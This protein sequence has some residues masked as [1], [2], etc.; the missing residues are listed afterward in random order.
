[1]NKEVEEFLNALGRRDLDL[2]LSSDEIQGLKRAMEKIAS[3]ARLAHAI[4]ERPQ[5]TEMYECLGKEL[6]RIGDSLAF[7]VFQRTQLTEVLNDNGQQIFQQISIIDIPVEDQ[8]F[9][10]DCGIKNPKD[11]MTISLAKLKN[12]YWFYLEETKN[13]TN[14]SRAPI[15]AVMDMA[16]ERLSAASADLGRVQAQQNDNT[17]DLSSAPR[18]HKPRKYF[19]G[20][21]KI[22]SGVVAGTGNVLIGV[23]AIPASGGAATAGVIASAALSIGIVMQ[24]IGDLRGE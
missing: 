7:R 10:K 11:E 1:M 21:G 13:P 22:L 6:H 16:Q 23:G 8:D 18:R 2:D 20:I 17:D 12:G 15:E 24:G 14:R 9:L 4:A 5:Q 3:T 19:N